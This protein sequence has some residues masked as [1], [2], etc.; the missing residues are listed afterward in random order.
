[1]TLDEAFDEFRR[2]VMVIADEMERRYIGTVV[3][4]GV[5][6]RAEA[7]AACDEH[8][9]RVTEALEEHLAAWRDGL[10]AKFGGGG[11]WH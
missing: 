9:P 8:R 3:D 7:E 5:M 10:R 2:R 11:A 6:T 1:M 4:L